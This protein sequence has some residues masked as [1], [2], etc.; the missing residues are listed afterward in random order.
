MLCS[1]GLLSNVKEYINELPAL[2]IKLS[3]HL[4][5]SRKLTN[6]P[7]KSVF[8]V[9]RSATGN[10]L[11]TSLAIRITLTEPE[12]FWTKHFIKRTRP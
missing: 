8:E 1:L 6:A 10:I 7:D 2:R 4:S 9:G 5:T 11:L 12:V 3:L